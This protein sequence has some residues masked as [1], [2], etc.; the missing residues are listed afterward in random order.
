MLE[1]DVCG[2]Q[3]V[4]D[5]IAV[6]GYALVCIHDEL[7]LFSESHRGRC[8]LFEGKTDIPQTINTWNDSD[9]L[10]RQ[11]PESRASSKLEHESYVDWPASQFVNAYH[12]F[13][14]DGRYELGWRKTETKDAPVGPCHPQTSS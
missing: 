12:S 8:H 4:I 5:L 9:G 2:I 6:V 1:Y 14:T 10:M 11:P 7:R 13:Y 3:V